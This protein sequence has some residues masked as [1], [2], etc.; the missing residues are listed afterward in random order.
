MDLVAQYLKYIESLTGTTPTIKAMEPAV[1]G[2]LPLYLRGYYQL[3]L[4]SLFGHR[5]FLAIQ[6]SDAESS[7]PS[8]YARHCDVLCEILNEE[9]ALVLPGITFYGRQQLVRLGVPFVVPH[10]QAFLP[11]RMVDLREGF[12]RTPEKGTVRLA[13]A[14][15]VVLLRDLLGKPIG[16]FSLRELAAD[17]GYSAMTLSTVR[18]ELEVLGLCATDQK[19]RSS[20][21]VFQAKGRA[22]WEKAEPHLRNPVRARHWVRRLHGNRKALKAGLTALAAATLVSDDPIPTF[23]MKAADFRAQ[24]EKGNL[25]GCQGPEDATERIES[26]IYDPQLLSHGPAVDTLSLYLSLRNTHDERVAGAV[27]RLIE[28]MPW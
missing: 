17:L 24:L 2:R 10:R 3:V 13:A 12:P 15:Q 9:V 27:K 7:T 26:W 23:A 21:L 20:H 19:G 6:N 14:A 25:V 8:E 18:S 4:S 5:L 1:F 11:P 22:L 28:E 16:T